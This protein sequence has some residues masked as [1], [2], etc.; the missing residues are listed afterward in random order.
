M[1]DR[2]EEDIIS[3]W[4]DTERC[5]VTIRC[6]TYN[7]VNFLSDA[8]DSFLNQRTSFPFEI[9]VHDDASTDGT[10]DLLLHYQKL[11]P[12][13]I[14]AIIQKNNQYSLGN[15]NLI[16]KM[17]NEQITGKYVAI[18]EGDDY[19]SDDQKLQIQVDYMEKH[20]NCVLTMH[21]G[22]LLNEKT[23]KVDGKINPYSSEKNLSSHEVLVENGKLPPTA[24]MVY[25]SDVIK[26]QPMD[27]FT[28]PVGDR[29]LRMYLLTKGD[30]YY[31]DKPMCVHRYNQGGSAFGARV[32]NDPDY[33]KQIYDQMVV[34][35]KKYDEYTNHQY[36]DDVNLLISREEY[37]YYNRINQKE[38]AIQTKYFRTMFPKHKVILSTIKYRLICFL[39]SVV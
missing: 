30:I 21:N 24:S 2:S 17:I 18:C 36:S 7:H 19:W 3:T 34:F 8:L 22:L 4:S 6:I 9:I 32:K 37:N 23:H 27:V 29:P 31:F 10:T 33:A 39:K 15:I 12:H 14:K 38:K 16:N 20:P 1:I 26:K 25:V 13:I 5:M 11:F 28:A 35:F